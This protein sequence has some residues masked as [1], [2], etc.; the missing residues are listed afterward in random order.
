[1]DDILVPMTRGNMED[2]EN[3]GRES[4]ESTLEYSSGLNTQVSSLQAY[5]IYFTPIQ[6]LNMQWDINFTSL[7]I[8]SNV[9]VIPFC[10][11]RELILHIYS[12]I[13]YVHQHL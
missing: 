11:D 13:S 10:D 1:M 8:H 12:F 9:I 5:Y 7:L 2:I 4:G 3:E 6:S